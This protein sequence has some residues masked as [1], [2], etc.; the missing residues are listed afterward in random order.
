M[1]LGQNKP[2]HG[3]EDSPCQTHNKLGKHVSIHSRVVFLVA[4]A[5]RK[6]KSST[7]EIRRHTSR[8][9]SISMIGTCQILLDDKYLDIY[10]TGA[11][12]RRCGL[13]SE[14]VVV[15]GSTEAR[16]FRHVCSSRGLVFAKTP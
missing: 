9:K 7:P 12:L 2:H 15:R 10:T 8:D 16:S 1:R 11:P 3:V 4:H 14:S 6:Y 13:A 5:G